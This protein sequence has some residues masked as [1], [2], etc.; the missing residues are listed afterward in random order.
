M[1]VLRHR[2]GMS[3]GN[4]MGNISVNVMFDCNLNELK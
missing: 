4:G 1:R 3:R 2:I